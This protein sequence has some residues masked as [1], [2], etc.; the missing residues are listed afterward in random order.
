MTDYATLPLKAHDNRFMFL[1]HA[2]NIGRAYRHRAMELIS[3]CQLLSHLAPPKLAHED[4]ELR[5]MRRICDLALRSAADSGTKV[6][7]EANKF[8]EEA[9]QMLSN[10]SVGRQRLDFPLTVYSK[11]EIAKLKDSTQRD[12]SHPKSEDEWGPTMAINFML[13][14]SPLLT[15]HDPET[16]IVSQELSVDP[17]LPEILWNFCRYKD[18][19]RITLEQNPHFYLHCPGDESAL[20][21]T[22]RR[23]PL[24]D[25]SGALEHNDT[26]YVL[27]DRP[28]RVFF[29]TGHKPRIFGNV[30]LLNGCLVFRDSSGVL[31]GERLVN[32]SSIRGKLYYREQPVVYH[33]P[34]SCSRLNHRCLRS[35]I[36]TPANP[37]L[38]GTFE[39]WTVLSRPAPHS[40]NIHIYRSRGSLESTSSL[41]LLPPP[42][43]SERPG[44]PVHYTTINTLNDDI[45]L[46]IF[47]HYRLDDENS[48]NVQLGWCKLS[49]VYRRWRYLV[50]SSAFHLGMH[51][52]CTNGTP[53]VD[54]LDH[55]PPLPLFVDYQHAT[56][57]IGEKDE[58]G[59]YHALLQRDRIRRIVLHL[60]LPP[61]VFH[62]FLMLMDEPF[63]ILEH[64]S[65]SS[66][67]DKVTSLMLP[68]TFLAPK[69]RHLALLGVGLPKGLPFLS[70]VSLVTLS[71]TEIRASGYF[72]PGQ[73]VARLQ[74]LPQLEELTISFSIPIP[75]P[76]AE[77]ELLGEQG[78]PVTLPRLKNVK[79]QGVSAYL[80]HLVSQIRAP[81]LVKFDITLFGQ[82]AFALP[83]LSH[84]VSRTEG[85][86][87]PDAR[88]LIWRDAVC[89]TLA[90]HVMNWADWNDGRFMLRVMCK[91][92]DW[93]I[94]CAAQICSA[95]IPAL[96]GVE[97]LRL[98]FHEPMLPTEW[99]N[100][101]IDGTTWHELLRPFIGVK[102]LRICHSLSEELSCALEVDEI[103][104]DPGFL[105]SLQGLVNEFK[106]PHH[107]ASLFGSFI[108]A[109]RVTGHPVRPS[110]VSTLAVQRARRRRAALGAVP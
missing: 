58:L 93:Q 43:T 22:F 60:H 36:T 89:I 92:L 81:L 26:V 88:V 86:K 109:R 37:S 48:W 47:N 105:P 96:S 25:P 56:A 61:L 73:L 5:R 64:L 100:G 97:E 84:F 35:I 66:T 21:P 12:W 91:Q 79:F 52:L 55:L 82:I 10:H 72:L 44:Y 29:D 71:L 62:K 70:T 34:D 67:D 51:I 11:M 14:Q 59:I 31:E 75:R 68:S 104:L 39:D 38:G 30:W 16:I 107:G 95:L 80:E 77:R 53:I 24:Q 1:E 49:H 98:D 27:F 32:S 50:Y 33:D 85:L 65:L 9:T 94:D 99:Q 17:S 90:P 7:D 74:S 54:T 45:L 78:S 69:L 4:A 83:R 3:I 15:P 2:W 23:R 108:Q 63:P 87:L 13:L 42:P 110:N 6:T 20:T 8:F 102:R 28:G 18:R 57:T 103:G 41:G 101:E 46:G 19:A 76:S 40:I 106:G